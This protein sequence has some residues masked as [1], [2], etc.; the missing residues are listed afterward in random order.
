MEEEGG[1]IQLTF[2]KEARKVAITR[3]ESVEHTGRN[4]FLLTNFACYEN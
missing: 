2:D 1:E 3:L 4:F